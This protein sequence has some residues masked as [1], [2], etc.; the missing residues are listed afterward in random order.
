MFAYGELD[1]FLAMLEIR[2]ML[3]LFAF[4]MLPTA[5]RVDCAAVVTSLALPAGQ[6]ISSALAPYRAKGYIERRVSG[7]YRRR[8]D[9]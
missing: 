6:S 1:I 2:Y 5:T 8:A 7:A 3:T 9:V 4:D